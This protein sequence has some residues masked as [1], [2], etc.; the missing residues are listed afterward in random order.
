MAIGIDEWRSVCS[1]DRM[2]NHPRNMEYALK[3]VYDCKYGQDY[4][5]EKR[6][7]KF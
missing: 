5:V 6:I 7:A 2:H 3:I 4:A 1:Y